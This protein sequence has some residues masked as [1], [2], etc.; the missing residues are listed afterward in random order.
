MLNKQK[1]HQPE[2]PRTPEKLKSIWIS[3]RRTKAKNFYQEGASDSKIKESNFLNKLYETSNKHDKEDAHK[4][5]FSKRRFEFQL[6]K[7][8]F[9]PKDVVDDLEPISKLYLRRRYLAQ[10]QI[11]DIIAET[12]SNMKF[13]KIDKF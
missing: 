4:I 3:S 13:L 7:Y 5:D 2:V 11:A 6:D 8:T 10:L 12:D 9:T 1:P